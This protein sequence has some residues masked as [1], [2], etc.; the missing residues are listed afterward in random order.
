M[1]EPWLRFTLAALATWR[2][3]ALMAY[4][5]GPWDMVVRLRRAAGNGGLG[6]MLDCFRCLSLWVAA[7]LALLV[8]RAPLDTLLVWLALSGAA[9]LLDR[10]TQPAATLL[11]LDDEG[12][13][14][15]LLRTEAL[16][17]GEPYAGDADAQPLGAVAGADADY[18]ASRGGTRRAGR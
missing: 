3:A 18:Y 9:C 13:A 2:V 12:E 1:D 8:A 6:R 17:A 10:I 16:R 4:D 11:N 14:D 5:D 7:P 15:E